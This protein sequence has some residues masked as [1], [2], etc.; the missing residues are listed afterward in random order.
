[1][2]ARRQLTPSTPVAGSS[3]VKNPFSRRP[4]DRINLDIRE[5][6]DVTTVELGCG[7]NLVELKD[8]QLYESR[9]R[10][11]ATRAEAERE[12]RGEDHQ[13]RGLVWSRSTQHQ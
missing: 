6:L 1:V 2:D 13:R 8:I 4:T 5:I 12:K 9:K 3:H 7:S 11:M 10:A